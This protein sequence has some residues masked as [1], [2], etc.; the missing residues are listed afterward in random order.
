MELVGRTAQSVKCRRAGFASSLKRFLD[1][2]APRAWCCVSRRLMGRT[3]LYFVQDG[4][5]LRDKNPSF[6]SGHS[7]W[8][9]PRTRNEIYPMAKSLQQFPM[10]RE[11]GRRICRT[12]KVGMEGAKRPFWKRRHHHLRSVHPVLCRRSYSTQD[13]TQHPLA[14]FAAPRSA[15]QIMCVVVRSVPVCIPLRVAGR[16]RQSPKLFP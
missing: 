15:R 7:T 13:G 3:Q 9:S 14:W 4:V 8:N 2:H 12:L 11:S 16:G 1:C 5:Q 6:H 10:R